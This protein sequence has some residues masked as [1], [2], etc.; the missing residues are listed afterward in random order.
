MLRKELAVAAGGEPAG[1]ELG[2]KGDQ[3]R[4]PHSRAAEVEARELELGLLQQRY[5]KLTDEWLATIVLSVCLP[6]ADSVRLLLGQTH[7]TS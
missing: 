2:H 6:L 3:L 5:P 4:G 1:R 7:Y